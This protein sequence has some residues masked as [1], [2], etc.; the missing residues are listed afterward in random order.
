MPALPYYRA[1]P[2]VAFP[3]GGTHDSLF[4]VHRESFRSYARSLFPR[5]EWSPL[6]T[7]EERLRALASPRSIV[8]PE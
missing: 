7:D 2:A 8:L 4:Q 1:Q 3:I 5:G 6:E